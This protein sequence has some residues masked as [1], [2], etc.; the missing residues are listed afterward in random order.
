[1]TTGRDGTPWITARRSTSCFIRETRHHATE[2]L[3]ECRLSSLEPARISARPSRAAS[4]A[5]GCLSAWCRGTGRSSSASSGDLAR[6][7]ITPDFASADIRDA[8]AL[9]SAIGSPADR[10]GA[11]E[12][13]EYSPVP[14]REY[15][16]PV[17]ETSVDDVRAAL[18]F[19]VLGAVAAL[20]T[21]IEP[22]LDRGSGTIL[23]TTGGAANQPQP[24]PHG[25]GNLLRRRSRLRPDAPR[26]TPRPGHPC[27]AHRDRR[28]H[29][30]GRRSPPGRRRRR[31]LAPPRERGGFQILL[32]INSWTDRR[33]TTQRR[34]GAN[35]WCRQRGWTL[36][37]KVAFV[38]G[39]ASGIGRAAAL[40]FARAGASV[41]VADVSDGNRETVR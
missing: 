17:L 24:G 33:A 22:M 16:Q 10:L 27:R 20:R 29:R 12:V 37:D 11:I 3:T 2:D 21:V 18:E 19:S 6:E 9:S 1:L 14:A 4:G 41:V 32:G 28:R 15:M 35:A 8:T 25:C 13:L 40:A 26:R 31:P 7:G 30:P 5:K 23:F 36:A 38:T 39:A 34:A